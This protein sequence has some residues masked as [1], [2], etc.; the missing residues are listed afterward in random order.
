MSVTI[1]FT[2]YSDLPDLISANTHID[3]HGQIQKYDINCTRSTNWFDCTGTPCCVFELETLNA[4]KSIE[5]VLT[6]DFEAQPLETYFFEQSNVP[7]WW[8]LY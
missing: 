1:A 2:S 8:N 3:Y 6:A 7:A 4:F 5:A